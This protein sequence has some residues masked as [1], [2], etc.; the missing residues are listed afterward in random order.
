MM[1]LDQVEV[2]EGGAVERTEIDFEGI[3]GS[4]G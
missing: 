2:E 1:G 4:I 3:A